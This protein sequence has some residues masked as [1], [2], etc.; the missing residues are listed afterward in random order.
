M[1]AEHKPYVTIYYSIGG[2]KAVRRDWYEGEDDN[3]NIR[4]M[5]DNTNTGCGYKTAEEA[6][7]DAKEWAKA[8]EID[9]I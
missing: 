7:I 2:W 3:G 6:R 8:E 4:G 9:F 5:Y 1:T